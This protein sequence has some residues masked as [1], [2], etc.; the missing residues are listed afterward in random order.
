MALSQSALLEVL[1]ALNASD[2]TDVIRTAAAGDV[3]GAD[4]R[5]S[6]RGDRRR[7]PRA[8]RCADD[9]AQRDAGPGR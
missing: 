2:A 3:A 4:R 8:H 6:D 9:A 7:A 1:D 5:R